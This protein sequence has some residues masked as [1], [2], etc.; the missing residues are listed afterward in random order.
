MFPTCASSNDPKFL[1]VWIKPGN[2]Q[3]FTHVTFRRPPPYSRD[4]SAPPMKFAIIPLLFLVGPLPAGE[5]VP[6]RIPPS[7]PWQLHADVDA[8]RA[9]ETGKTLFA[10]I[11]ADHGAKLR[12]FKRMF[13]LHPLNDLHGITLYG[14]GK[15]EHAVALIDG[16]FD[17]AHIEDVVRAADGY[18]PGSHAGYAVHHWKDKG[19]SQHAAF[20]SDSLLVFS[21]QRDLLHDALDVL[22]AN[23]PAKPDAFFAANGGK[24]L[25]AASARLSEIDM[26]GDEARLVR[27][28][29]TLRVAFNEHGGR[30]TVRIGAETADATNAEQLRRMLD[31]VIAFAQASDARFDGLDLRADL[32]TDA[33][34][35]ALKVALSL[36]VTEWIPLM[37]K[38]AGNAS[39]AP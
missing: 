35:P 22:K 39:P 17:R 37:E 19:I 14:D 36:P 28:A 15:P 26:P 32:A 13:S 27:M 38:A 34:Q 2:P 6:S 16:T 23:A 9:S 18:Q 31:G 4:K 21:R 5:I 3:N 12:A 20:A 30:F 11:E 1:E 25:I 29:R 10:R 24:P 7:A 33:G 8:M